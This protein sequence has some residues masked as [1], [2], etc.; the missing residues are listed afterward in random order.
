M[1]CGPGLGIVIIKVACSL[2]TASAYLVESV[3]EPL[4]YCTIP[5]QTTR[6][7]TP[8]LVKLLKQPN[9]KLQVDPN[10]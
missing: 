2:F 1:L 10:T 3:I 7:G 4:E 8:P 9:S 5:A 6:T